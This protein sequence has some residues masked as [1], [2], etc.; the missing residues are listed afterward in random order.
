MAK[1]YPSKNEKIYLK[2]LLSL[3]HCKRL[4]KIAQTVR[5]QVKSFKNDRPVLNRMLEYF[6]LIWNELFVGIFVIGSQHLMI[7]IF[8][9]KFW[10]QVAFRFRL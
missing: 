2:S 1:L 8:N 9:S 6:F 10:K 5:F 3:K 4:V 7:F